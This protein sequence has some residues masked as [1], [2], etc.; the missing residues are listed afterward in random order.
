M[1]IKDEHL[2]YVKIIKYN[3]PEKTTVPSGVIPVEVLI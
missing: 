2:A 1:I 3:E